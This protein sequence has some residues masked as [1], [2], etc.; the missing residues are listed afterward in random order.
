MNCDV[1]N[2]M[3]CDCR[4]CRRSASQRRCRGI[5][6]L[7]QQLLICRLSAAGKHD[8]PSARL[9]VAHTCNPLQPLHVHTAA[10]AWTAPFS[11][12]PAA[13]VSPSPRSSCEGGVAIVSSSGD[14]TAI[15]HV[16]CT[17]RS[18]ARHSRQVQCCRRNVGHDDTRYRVPSQCS[19]TS[20][21]HGLLAPLLLALMEARQEAPAKLNRK[22]GT[23]P[24]SRLRKAMAD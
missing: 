16:I 15:K 13:A 23:S 11:G 6:Q 5:A 7:T 1:Q 24:E 12:P 3:L 21:L 8:T 4:C 17:R 10:G 19:C 2:Q 9:P 18:A 22:L 20:A 14:A